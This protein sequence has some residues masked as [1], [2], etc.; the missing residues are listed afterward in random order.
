MYA[1]VTV[2]QASPEQFDQDVA[3]IQ[4]HLLPAV[5]AMPGIKGAYFL[6]SRETGKGITISLWDT[7]EEMQASS[8]TAS[9]AR[10]DAVQSLSVN[11]QGVDNY[12]IVA[13]L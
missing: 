3:Y 8:A 4:E 12:E 1:R 9:Q 2:T 6:V 10:S 11:V 7:E 5:K 13:Q